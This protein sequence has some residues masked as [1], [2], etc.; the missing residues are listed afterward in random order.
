MEW[1]DN[2]VD[3]IDA[4]VVASVFY[5]YFS[6]EDQAYRLWKLEQFALAGKKILNAEY[7]ELALLDEY[8][9]MLA[10]QSFEI[11]GYPADPDRLL[12]ELVLY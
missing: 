6:A 7:I 9:G 2:Y 8:F 11:L 4:V 10:M 5:D 1:R 3:D 12:D